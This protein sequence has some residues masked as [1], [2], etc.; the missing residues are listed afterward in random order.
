[1]VGYI[2]DFETINHA[3]LVLEFCNEGD[4]EKYIEKKNNRRITEDEA[5]ELT[6]SEQFMRYQ[7]VHREYFVSFSPTLV[8]NWRTF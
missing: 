3:Y 6:D 7:V 2:D 8:S 5:I 1:M 4:L